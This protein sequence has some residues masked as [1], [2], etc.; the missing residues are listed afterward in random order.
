MNIISNG[1][2]FRRGT[3]SPFDSLQSKDFDLGLDANKV[4]C[5]WCR[6]CMMAVDT[7]I[8]KYN[9]NQVWG[10]K[11]WCKRCGAVTQSAVYY[12]VADIGA[13]QTDLVEKA[14]S[15]ADKTEVITK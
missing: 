8:E 3:G 15:W 1:Y 14:K 6:R 13:T 9:Q 11:Q 4:P 7:I 10:M 5:Q 2:R 12:H